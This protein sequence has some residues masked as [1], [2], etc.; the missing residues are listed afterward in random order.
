MSLKW[1][2]L[3]SCLN[4]KNKMLPIVNYFTNL[5]EILKYNSV[6]NKKPKVEIIIIYLIASLGEN[7]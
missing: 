7:N 2:M 5:N 3:N 6:L 4:S 1:K